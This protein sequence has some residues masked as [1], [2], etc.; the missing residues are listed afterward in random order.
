MLLWLGSN[1]PK[2]IEDRLPDLE[3]HLDAVEISHRR[4]GIIGHEDHAVPREA[5]G[6]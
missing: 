3:T 1:S 4:E 6:S 2:Q 5:V